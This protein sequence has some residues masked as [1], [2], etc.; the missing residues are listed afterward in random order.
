METFYIKENVTDAPTQLEMMNKLERIEN[1]LTREITGSTVAR[2]I[3]VTLD[4]AAKCKGFSKSFG[5]IH[6][7]IKISK[8]DNPES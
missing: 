8:L 7:I 6:L 3:I 4:E 1:L 2:K 5:T